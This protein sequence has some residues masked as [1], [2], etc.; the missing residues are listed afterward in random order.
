MTFVIP[1][2][3]SFPFLRNKAHFPKHLLTTVAQP[4]ISQLDTPKL[5][6]SYRVFFFLTGIPKKVYDVESSYRLILLGGS[7]LKNNTLKEDNFE[8]LKSYQHKLMQVQEHLYSVRQYI[9]SK[10]PI[11]RIALSVGWFVTFFTPPNAHAHPSY[12]RVCT[13]DA[14]P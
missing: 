11:P 7:Q 9:Y 1:S 8:G 12:V 5:A 2:Q 14:H 10:N 3:V 6:F 13:L 4:T